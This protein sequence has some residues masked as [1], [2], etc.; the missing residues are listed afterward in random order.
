[1]FEQEHNHSTRK[2]I[3]F[4]TYNRLFFMNCHKVTTRV[5][6]TSNIQLWHADVSQLKKKKSQKKHREH[7]QSICSSIKTTWCQAKILYRSDTKAVHAKRESLEHSDTTF[8]ADTSPLMSGGLCRKMTILKQVWL[9]SFPTLP[10][11]TSQ[12]GLLNPLY[13][14]LSRSLENDLPVRIGFLSAAGTD[15]KQLQS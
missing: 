6:L 3:L 14:F 12:A 2:Q 8:Q 7:S 13:Y 9:S 4:L 15:Q 11:G 5:G 1:M 10:L